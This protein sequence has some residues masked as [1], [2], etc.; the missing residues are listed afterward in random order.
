MRN[1]LPAVHAMLEQVPDLAGTD[2][3]LVKV[4]T[5]PASATEME[6]A[7]ARP[8]LAARTVFFMERLIVLLL[9]NHAEIQTMPESEA[10][11][12]GE[13]ERCLGHGN[14][15]I[16]FAHGQR[17]E[18][19]GPANRVLEGMHEGEREVAVL[20]HR[21]GE[22]E[23]DVFFDGRRGQHVE[24]HLF[25]RDRRLAV[26]QPAAECQISGILVLDAELVSG[27][28]FPAET[29]P[30]VTTRFAGILVRRITE[31]IKLS[32]VIGERTGVADG[33][34]VIPHDAL[35]VGDYLELGGRLQ[36][37]A[38]RIALRYVELAVIGEESGITVEF[39]HL[40]TGGIYQTKGQFL[41]K[42]GSEPA[43]PVTPA[44]PPVVAVVGEMRVIG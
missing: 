8:R 20:V 11:A 30:E 24:Q 35:N 13:A 3:P 23:R 26:V 7:K 12:I 22:T 28:I 6:P 4:S 34:H 25:F 10:Q 9:Q 42:V 40:D 15:G 19:R 1:S 17:R 37:H 29:E 33:I 21:C 41:I 5:R 2:V 31:R 43:E 44:K 18:R 38:H 39:L 32:G 27:L 36:G 14:T 16:V